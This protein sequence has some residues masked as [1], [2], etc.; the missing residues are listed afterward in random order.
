MSD[1]SLGVAFQIESCAAARAAF[2]LFSRG[3]WGFAGV[4]TL[5]G[6]SSGVAV[7]F[8][9]GS[10]GS[11]GSTTFTTATNTETDDADAQHGKKSK[12]LHGYDLSLV[13]QITENVSIGHPAPPKTDRR[14]G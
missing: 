9:C 10:F 2:G 11:F 12:L 5:S 6:R 7:A 1:L 4:R 13:S 3:F 8:G 14:F